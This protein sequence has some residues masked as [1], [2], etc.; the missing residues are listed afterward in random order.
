MNSIRASLLALALLAS[1]STTDPAD[2]DARARELAREF[3]IVDG[4]VDVP[5]RLH[6]Q[7]KGGQPPDDVSVR[8]T[9]GDFDLPRAREGGL[10]AP[11][12]SIYTPSEEEAKGNSKALADELIDMVEAIVA[13]HP[14]DFAIARTESDVRKIA[15]SGRIALLL[16]MENGSPIAGDLA[17][18][19]HFFARGVRYITLCHGKDNHIC[20]SS[21]DTT[22]TH[23]GLS[24]FGREVVRRMN[25]LGIL[26]D[27]SHLSDD[28][29]WQAVE[30]SKAPVIA[31]HSS[32][33][34]FVPGFER[35]VDDEMVKKIGARGGVVMINFGSGF[36]LRDANEHYGKRM[37]AAEAFAAELG[38][39]QDSEKL[40]PLLEK[41]DR[42]NPMPF[43]TVSNVADH[44]DRAVELA[45]VDHVG[46]G[47]D[48]DGV[49]PTLPIGLKDVSQYPNLIAELL[50]R[51]YS[52]SDIEKICGENALRV[53][54]EAE[55]VARDLRS[56]APAG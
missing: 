43:A 5:Y 54:R 28:A 32:L 48:F 12:F 56:R 51:G 42:E 34:Y 4:H 55:K 45:G 50:R 47:S 29:L 37:K 16:G 7:K 1:C 39:P 36:I 11:F 38:V 35:N 8:T 24:P 40:A 25:E 53:L 26:V 23:K 18:L 3:L 9:G 31:S 41:W 13:A 33:R 27:V 21:Y 17:N 20:D 6:E 14:S 2:I 46:L 22:R 15:G 52:E 44:I 19:D 30:L 10:D 49:G